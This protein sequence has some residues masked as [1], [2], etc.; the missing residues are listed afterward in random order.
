MTLPAWWTGN[1]TQEEDLP[2]CKSEFQDQTWRH[3]N[4]QNTSTTKDKAGGG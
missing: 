2:F 1:L 3:G 4:I